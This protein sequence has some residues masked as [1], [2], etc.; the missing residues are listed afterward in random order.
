[1][2]LNSK[3]RFLLTTFV[4]SDRR[5]FRTQ[6]LGNINFVRSKELPQRAKQNEE[7]LPRPI[8]QSFLHSPRPRREQMNRQNPPRVGD[9][10]FLE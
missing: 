7:G 8:L 2:E 5:D 4:S 6:V 9:R 3:A 10:F 1:M